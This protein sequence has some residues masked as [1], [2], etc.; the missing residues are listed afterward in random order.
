MTILQGAVQGHIQAEIHDNL[1]EQVVVSIIEVDLA[2]IERPVERRVDVSSSS[3]RH[4]R[5]QKDDKDA[6]FWNAHLLHRDTNDYSVYFGPPIR[7]MRDGGT[8]PIRLIRL[9]VTTEHICP[10][11][12]LPCHVVSTFWSHTLDQ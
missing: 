12:E 2:P 5:W 1:K 11:M 10:Y 7:K 3:G 4:L 9:V 6:I 8:N